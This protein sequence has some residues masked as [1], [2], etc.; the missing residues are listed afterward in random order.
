VV[1]LTTKMTAIHVLK[2]WK[3]SSW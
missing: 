2:L 1:K 3:Q